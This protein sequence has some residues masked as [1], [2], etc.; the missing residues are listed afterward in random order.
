MIRRTM[1]ALIAA[2]SASP[3][4]LRGK[5]DRHLGENPG[6]T[7]RQ[8]EQAVAKAHCVV[9]VMGNQQ[10]YHGA[11]V[12]NSGDLIAQT[13]GQRVIERGQRLVENQEVRLDRRRRGPAPRGGQG[14]A[15]AR[16]ENGCDA[17]SNSRT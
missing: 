9:D 16:R 13:R 3:R 14:R 10:R 8:Q 17:R 6:R 5:C 2:I 12:H 15:I 7:R 4:R 1:P 11:A